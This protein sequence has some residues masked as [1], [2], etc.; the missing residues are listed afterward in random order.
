MQHAVNSN[1]EPYIQTRARTNSERPPDSTNMPATPSTISLPADMDRTELKSLLQ[2]ALTA[3][4][5]TIV[6]RID[7]MSTEIKELHVKT[8][9]ILAS[10]S[11]NVE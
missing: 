9:D 11:F 2:E 7:A 5:H 6:S 1:M 10:V 8:N 3:H 4:T